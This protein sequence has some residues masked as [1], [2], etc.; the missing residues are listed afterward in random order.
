M[1]TY[2]DP[3]ELSESSLASTFKQN[4]VPK[5]L[6]MVSDEDLQNESSLAE[7]ACDLNL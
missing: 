4:H 5:T 6:V 3:N 1:I 7:S 2:E